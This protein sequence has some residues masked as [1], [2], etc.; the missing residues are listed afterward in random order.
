[1]DTDPTTQHATVTATPARPNPYGALAWEHMARWLPDRL[2]QIPDPAAYFRDLGEQ[3]AELI[4]TTTDSLA[5]PPPPQE[6]Y[7]GTVGRMRIARLMAE[8]K[9]LAETV[10][11]P[12]TADPDDCPRDPTGAYLGHDPQMSA[13]WAPLWDGGDPDPQP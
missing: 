2:A 4:E 7:W 8:E 1:M 13:S 11:L 5:G 6:D 12:P 10:F 9:V 3:V